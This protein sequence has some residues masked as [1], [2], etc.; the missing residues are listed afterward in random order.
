MYDISDISSFYLSRVGISDL[1]V[2]SD[3]TGLVVLNFRSDYQR[4]NTGLFSESLLLDV[5]AGLG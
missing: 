3:M 1:E 2:Q 4:M 5:V